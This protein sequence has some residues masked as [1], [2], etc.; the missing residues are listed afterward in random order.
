MKVIRM[1]QAETGSTPLRDP[2]A[3]SPSGAATQ[4]LELRHLRYFVAV[5]DAGTFTHAA[6]RLFIAQPTLSQ[7]IRRLEQIVGTPLLWRQR[8]GV[9]LTAA[10]TVLLDASRNVLSMA[11]HAVSQTRLA[12][13][14]GRLRLRFVLS[15]DLPDSLAV[16]TTSRLRSAAEAGGAALT[17]LE[18]TLDA[19]FSSI[20]ER[21]ADAGLGWLTATPD[22]LSAALD[23]MSLGEFEPDV[24]IPSSHPAARRGVISLAELASLDVIYGPRRASPATYDRWLQVLRTADPRFEFTDPPFRRSLPMALAFAATAD[25]PTGVLT[26]P[27]AIA[28]PPS[29][30]TRLPRPTSTAD[31]TRASIAGHPADR[32]GRPGMARRPAPPAPA[33][34]VRH[35]RRRAPASADIPGTGISAADGSPAGT[36][37]RG[38]AS[39]RRDSGRLGTTTDSWMQPGRVMSGRWPT[40]IAVTGSRPKPRA[41]G[42]PTDPKATRLPPSIARQGKVLWQDRFHGFAVGRSIWDAPTEGT[43]PSWPGP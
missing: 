4:N 36:G 27:S 24:W 42:T 33:D 10:G 9:R 23:A 1:T 29:G 21:R 30:L 3:D 2:E 7:Q 13:G 34:P 11:D 14:L 35:R 6:E 22:A 8:D 18:T 17:W 28:G 12:A 31:M 15:A 39:G 38:R 19:D 25:R 32:H 20:R 26:G 37:L 40:R 43:S 16:T 5:A 41:Y